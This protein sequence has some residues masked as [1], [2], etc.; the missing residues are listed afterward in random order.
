MKLVMS[1]LA[2]ALLTLAL[3]AQEDATKQPPSKFEVMV[4]EWKAAKAAYRAAKDEVRETE[5]YKTAR[6]DRNIALM[7]KLTGVV[8]GPDSRAFG[9]RALALADESAGD[10]ALNVLTFA[11]TNFSEADIVKHMIERLTRDHIKS[12]EI[13]NLLKRS[14][15]FG[16][17][18]GK[19]ETT[20]FLSKVNAKNPHPLPRAYA[21][22]AMSQS[23]LSDR[24]ATAKD[25]DRAKAQVV[26]A[27]ELAKGSPYA[28]RTSRVRFEVENLLPGCQA[29]DIKGEDLDGTAFSLSDYRGKVVLLDFWGFW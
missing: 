4:A 27:D 29:P 13:V 10:E 22:L 20:D 17:L 18:I 25:L 8:K 19:K 14:R 28:A 3:P 21:L 7:R 26:E 24:G 2:L 15:T 6:A 5:A 9:K 23:T 12:K 1:V 11:A 16:R